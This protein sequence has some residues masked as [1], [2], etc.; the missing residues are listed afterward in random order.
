VIPGGIRYRD[1]LNEQRFVTGA[2]GEFAVTFAEPGMYWM[3]A[4]VGA[5][6]RGPGSGGQGPGAGGAP[7]G[8]RP[9]GGG[10]AGPRGIVMPAGDRA[11]YVATLEVL[12][13]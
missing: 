10:P 9:A 4:S 5:P 12:G 13:Q 2:N 7:G 11:S 1:R 6:Q 8:P 3:N